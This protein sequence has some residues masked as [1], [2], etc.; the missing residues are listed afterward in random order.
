VCE[1]CIRYRA[2][3]ETYWENNKGKNFKLS[4]SIL[5]PR[6]KGDVYPIELTRDSQDVLVFTHAYICIIKSVNKSWTESYSDESISAYALKH[7]VSFEIEENPSLAEEHDVEL[8]VNVL[9]QKSS[10][11]SFDSLGVNNEEENGEDEAPA[12]SDSGMEEEDDRIP[13]PQVRRVYKDHLV[14]PTIF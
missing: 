2:G 5:S 11:V 4:I 14:M 9:Q 8:P 7:L 1:F 13:T 10:Y 3:S 12:A 6:L